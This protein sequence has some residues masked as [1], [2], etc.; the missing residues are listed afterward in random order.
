MELENDLDDESE[1]L[2]A[3]YRLYRAQYEYM[4][5]I[6]SGTRWNN[7]LLSYQFI[8]KPDAYFDFC[9]EELQSIIDDIKKVMPSLEQ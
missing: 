7:T 1:Y 3:K 5:S 4:K 2:F 8:F 9:K 6:V